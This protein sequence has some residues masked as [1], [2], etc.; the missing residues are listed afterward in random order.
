ML[1]ASYVS[2]NQKFL[3]DLD[4]INVLFIRKKMDD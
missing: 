4:S 2:F 3:M 1:R